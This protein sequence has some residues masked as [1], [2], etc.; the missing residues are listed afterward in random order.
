MVLSATSALPRPTEGT[1]P[2]PSLFVC[3][4]DKRPGKAHLLTPIGRKGKPLTGQ[5][6]P[7]RLLLSKNT[8]PNKERKRSGRSLVSESTPASASRCRPASSL[9]VQTPSRYPY[10]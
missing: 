6:L 8:Y 4:T 2:G 5:V 10:A 9:T 1:R 3:I 7:H